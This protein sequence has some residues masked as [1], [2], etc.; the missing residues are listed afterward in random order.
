MCAFK[1]DVFVDSCGCCTR[2]R[3]CHK[4]EFKN[5]ASVYK[6]KGLAGAQTAGPLY[7]RPRFIS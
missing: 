6:Q 1:F 4:R 5:S 7:L 3:L 2:Q